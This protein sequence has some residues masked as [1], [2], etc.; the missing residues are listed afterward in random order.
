MA[1]ICN[2]CKKPI[3]INPWE[4]PEHMIENEFYCKKCYEKVFK[5]RMS[6]D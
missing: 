1:E 2:K 5:K 4:R 6:S 3:K